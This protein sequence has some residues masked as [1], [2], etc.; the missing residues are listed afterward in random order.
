LALIN[1]NKQQEKPLDV[2]EVHFVD[3][4]A[5]SLASSLTRSC[6]RHPGFA[7]TECHKMNFQHIQLNPCLYSQRILVLRFLLFIKYG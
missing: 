1:L 4:T 7:A 3:V 5:P 2:L 6:F